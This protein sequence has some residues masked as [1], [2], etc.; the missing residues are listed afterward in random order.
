MIGGLTHGNLSKIEQ[1]NGGNSRVTSAIDEMNLRNKRN[2]VEDMT[3][4]DGSQPAK[5]RRNFARG[6]SLQ[7]TNN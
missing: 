3:S 4:A 5:V 2:S 1:S 6:I 7:T